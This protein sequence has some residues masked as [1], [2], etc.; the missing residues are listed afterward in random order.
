MF[1]E[2]SLSL[3]TS[4]INKV[5]LI[6]YDEIII[7]HSQ[8]FIIHKHNFKCV[9]L[10]KVERKIKQQGVILKQVIIPNDLIIKLNIIYFYP[11]VTE[12]LNSNIRSLK[13][14]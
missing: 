5:K 14:I 3:Y 6:H 13:L 10:L 8:Q 7:S 4:R 12:P 1:K 2:K 9:H 11:R